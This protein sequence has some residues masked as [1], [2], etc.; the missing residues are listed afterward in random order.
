MGPI[1]CLICFF[2]IHRGLEKLE[3]E[4]MTEFSFWVIYTFKMS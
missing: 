3:D 4:L 1:N 2:K